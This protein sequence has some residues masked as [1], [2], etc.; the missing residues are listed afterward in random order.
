MVW[1]GVHSHWRL[2]KLNL[3]G[4][5]HGLS[6]RHGACSE[7]HAQIPRIY[8]KSYNTSTGITGAAPGLADQCSQPGELL[9]KDLISKRGLE[10]RDSSA[11]KDTYCQP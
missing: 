4:E 1:L 7:N 3:W 9:K 5:G 11:G 10:K 2:F 8:V 6:G